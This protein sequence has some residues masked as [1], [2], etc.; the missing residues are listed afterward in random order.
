[1]AWIELEHLSHCYQAGTEQEHRAL[2][3]VSL[4]VEEGA[5]VAVLGA[6]G[7]GKSTLAKHLNALLLPTSGACRINGLDTAAAADT[8]ELWKIRQQ[9]GMVFQNPDNQLIAAVVEDD[10]AF[11]PENL[12]MP[13]DEIRT[14]VR[15]AL[16]CVNMTHYRKF[17]PHLLSGGQ[18]QRVAIAGALAMKTRCLVLDEPTAMHDPQGRAEVMETVCRLHEQQGITIVLITHFMEEA[19]LADRVVVM[20]DGR[21]ADDGTPREIFRKAAAL[22][23][24][25]LDVPL[26]TELGLELRASGLDVPQ[27]ILTDDELTSALVTL[28]DYSHGLTAATREGRG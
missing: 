27:D 4:A 17:A 28:A 26:A 14:A 9:V 16:A 3:D 23:A 8:G 11:G 1:M 13:P 24:L 22:K 10:V 7:S 21:V 18:K 15:E 5:F 6:N 20:A 25:G 2:D 19:A 12:G